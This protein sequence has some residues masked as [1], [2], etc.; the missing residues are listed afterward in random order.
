MVSDFM[1]F[2]FKELC[3][4]NS[5]LI[6]VEIWSV[7]RKLEK[8]FILLDPIVFLLNWCIIVLLHYRL[9]A[10]KFFYLS[11]HCRFLLLH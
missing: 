5:R 9:F 8:G 2:L 4:P 10:L 1:I 7:T 6:F 11:L 3:F